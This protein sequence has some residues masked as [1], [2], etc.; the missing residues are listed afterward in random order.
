M[1]SLT[2]YNFLLNEVTIFKCHIW[3]KSKSTISH[4]E[5]NDDV[6][7]QTVN[8]SVTVEPPSHREEGGLEGERVMMQ[9][10]NLLHYSVS[11][12]N[13]AALPRVRL[14][15]TAD[16]TQR[17]GKRWER[18][19]GEVQLWGGGAGAAA[20]SQMWREERMHRE[21][22]HTTSCTAS[23]TVCALSLCSRAEEMAAVKEF[24][25]ISPHLSCLY[26]PPGPT[27][28]VFLIIV[29]GAKYNVCVCVTHSEETWKSFLS[30][31]VSLKEDI[32]FNLLRKT[33]SAVFLGR[34]KRSGFK[35]IPEMI[36]M[37]M[38]VWVFGK[39]MTIFCYY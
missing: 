13:L 11:G 9:K 30:K 28:N 37:M 21:V 6:K 19:T 18:K 14:S 2:L 36:E 23:C 20:G 17:L 5:K 25:T 22:W 12:C 27:W 4:G 39:N 10:S 26:S 32:R 1:S 8:T 15:F 33:K 34:S 24:A 7:K 3:N 16:E 35:L 31:D 38:V 29:S